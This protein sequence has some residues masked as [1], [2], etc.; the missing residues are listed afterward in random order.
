M[1]NLSVNNQL[2]IGT[3]EHVIV[4]GMTGSGKSVLAEIYLAGFQTSVVK[5]DTKGEAYERRK[6]GQELWRGL[7]EGKDFTVVEYLKDLEQVETL[8]VIYAPHFTEQD[9]EHYDALLK[10]V[11]LRE[12]TTLWIDELMEVAPSANRFPPYLKGVYTRGRS[13]EVSV[14][15]CSQRSLEIPGS[16]IGNTTHF[17]VFN[18]N[19]PQDRKKLADATGIMEF[20]EQPGQYN[21]WYFRL[22]D[23]HATL[24]TLKL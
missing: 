10:W 4:L 23:T 6:K 9:Q 5:L 7:V 1:K 18:M 3:D 15:S 14:W 22:G 8:K 20:Y 19:Q 12:N 24:G 2:F 13:K 21:F 11:Y 17:F 16:V